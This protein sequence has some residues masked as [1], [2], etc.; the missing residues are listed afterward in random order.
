MVY[1][2]LINKNTGQ[3]KKMNYPRLASAQRAVRKIEHGSWN[4][5]QLWEVE[6]VYYKDGRVAD[7]TYKKGFHEGLSDILARYS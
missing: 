4:P 3:V 5:Y 7:P 1:I 2:K 6:G